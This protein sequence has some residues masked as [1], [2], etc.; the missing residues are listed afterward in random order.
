MT[1]KADQYY[2]NDQETA[3]ARN[4]VNGLQFIGILP[5]EDGISHWKIWTSPG[6]W[7]QNQIM[8]L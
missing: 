8:L 2:E 4:Y 7:N 1:C 6:C 3:F 5:K